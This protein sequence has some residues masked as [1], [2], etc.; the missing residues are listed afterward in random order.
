MVPAKYSH[1][2]II[3]KDLPYNVSERPPDARLPRAG[4][5]QRGRIVWLDHDLQVLLG[6][7]EVRVFVDGIGLITVDPGSLKPAC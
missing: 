4:I 5:L 7:T 3:M 1:S 6:K 2:C